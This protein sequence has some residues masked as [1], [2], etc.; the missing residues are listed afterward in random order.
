MLD[1]EFVLALLSRWLHIL[2]AITAV[3]GTIFAR[4]VVFPALAPLPEEERTRL[5]AAL[6]VR[7]AMLVKAAIGFLLVS[8]LYNF[9]ITVSQYRVPSWYHMVFGI[10]FLLALAIFA[11][12]SLLIGK[13]PAAQAVR[14]RAP[15]WLNLN[16]A[17]A[18]AVVCLSGVLRTA[19]KTPKPAA[20]TPAEAA[21]ET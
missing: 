5:H 2:A 10:K 13:S 8:G 7:W 19:E 17:L 6:R 4:A 15:F 9:M 12:A 14:S 11:I 3:G 16:I 18:V 1:F 21:E 20:G